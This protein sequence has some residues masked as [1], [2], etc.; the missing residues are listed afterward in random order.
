[1]SHYCFKSTKLLSNKSKSLY[2]ITY[3]ILISTT[4]VKLIN[5]LKGVLDK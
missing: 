3:I 2:L 4:M 1:M 5:I